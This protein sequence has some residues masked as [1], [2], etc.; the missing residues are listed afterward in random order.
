MFVY[1][2]CKL[3]E[4]SLRDVYLADDQVIFE[5]RQRCVIIYPLKLILYHMEN[6]IWL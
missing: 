2:F 3:I 4:A 1:V 5:L 6:T